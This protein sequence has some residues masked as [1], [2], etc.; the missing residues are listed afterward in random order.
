MGKLDL[1]G[2]EGP[3]EPHF[4]EQLLPHHVHVGLQLRLDCQFLKILGRID[5]LCATHLRVG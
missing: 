3:E 5:H 1:S 2:Q 4:L